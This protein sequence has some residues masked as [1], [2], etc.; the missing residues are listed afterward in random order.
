MRRA[1]LSLILLSI[2][3]IPLAC[4]SVYRMDSRRPEAEARLLRAAE[5]VLARHFSATRIDWSR[6]V[7]EAR[8]V[9]GANLASKYRTFA[10]AT[11]FR[12]GR[13][14]YDCEIRVTNELEVSLASPGG[15]AQPGYDWRAAGFDKPLEAVLMAE[16]EAELGGTAVASRPPSS[17]YMWM[18]P[19]PTTSPLRHRDLFRPRVPD[20][21]PQPKAP[22]APP[23]PLPAPPPPPVPL[24]PEPK[25]GAAPPRQGVEQLFTQ[26]MT[27]GDRFMARREVDKALLEYQRAAFA[28]PSDASAHLSL[29]SAW[30]A[31]DRYPAAAE[32]LRQAADAA[33]ERP[34]SDGELRRLRTLSR[35]VAQRLLLLKGWLKKN[36]ADNDAR[37][38]LG[39]HCLL[40]DRSAEARQTLQHVLDKAPGD[41]AARYLMRQL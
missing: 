18:P 5:R 1:L 34:L 37:L 27:L 24:P 32:S 6:A 38:V 2:G 26:Y 17:Y 9:V 36:P 33:R 28:R 41:T 16:L 23:P 19:R 25:K 3:A 13:G 35:D 22:A 40:A 15:G 4:R 14:Q 8:S 21:R 10:V 30:S 12:T 11:V 29:A 31:L 7:V 39:Y 20:L